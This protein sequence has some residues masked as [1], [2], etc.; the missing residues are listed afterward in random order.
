MKTIENE[1]HGEINNRKQ[2]ENRNHHAISKYFLLWRIRH[3]FYTSPI[4]DL[5]LNG[6]TGSVLM[7]EQEEVLES[8]GKMYVRDDGK[9]P[10]R[11]ITGMQIRL[12]LLK[13]WSN[14]EFLQWGLIEA[15]EGEFLVADCYHDLTL[16]PISP[17]LAFC[18]GYK[19]QVISKLE[20]A[21]INTQ[22]IG[23]SSIFYFAKNLA[24]C[25]IA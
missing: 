16:M 1:F 17:K 23:K 19:D 21:E 14:V 6:I 15:K 18:A 2:F 4:I 10:A 5:T 9:V 24:E 22:S 8:N 12:E 11:F 20:V 3:H 7:G 25:P 13:Q